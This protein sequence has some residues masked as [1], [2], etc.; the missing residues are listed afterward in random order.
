[1]APLTL[2]LRQSSGPDPCGL[3]GKSVPPV[4]GPGLCRADTLAGVCRDCGKRHAPGLVAL[5]DLAEVAQRFA[6][7]G[8]HTLVPPLEALLAL[9][10]AAENYTAAAPDSCTQAA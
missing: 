4:A 3:C 6:R 1:M 2:G 5:L 7:V 9:A 10:Q 8:R